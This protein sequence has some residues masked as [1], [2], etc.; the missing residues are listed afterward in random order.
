MSADGGDCDEHIEG[1]EC[2]ANLSAL[3][4][5]P[6]Q[7]LHGSSAALMGPGRSGEDVVAAAVL[8]GGAGV[9]M[10]APRRSR[11]SRAEAGLDEDARDGSVLDGILPGEEGSGGISF[12]VDF[13][14]DSG[15][16]GGSDDDEERGGVRRMPHNDSA[17]APAAQRPLPPPRVARA[18]DFSAG[19]TTATSLSSTSSAGDTS[20]CGG[21]GAV[22][23]DSSFGAVGALP[24]RPIL[25]APTFLGNPTF[26]VGAPSDASRASCGAS[27]VSAASVPPLWGSGAVLKQR[28]FSRSLFAPLEASGGTSSVMP[29][30]ALPPH[31]ARKHPRDYLR[32]EAAAS[33]AAATAAASV[34]GPSSQD[35]YARQLQMLALDAAPALALQS[36]GGSF[37]THVPLGTISGSDTLSLAS[38][39]RQMPA[40]TPAR[41]RIARARRRQVQQVRPLELSGGGSSLRSSSGYVLLSSAL[42]G[43]GGGSGSSSAAAGASSSQESAGSSSAWEQLPV[44]TGAR[45]AFHRS[46]SLPAFPH[47]REG[48]EGGASN[49]FGASS[50]LGA[51]TFSRRALPPASPSHI[52]EGAS[53]STPSAKRANVG[54]SP[55]GAVD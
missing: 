8:G 15:W 25:L 46:S 30:P 33:A 17:A 28:A 51:T 23:V 45:A 1:G 36:S 43:C 35:S 39:A 48:G 27:G 2:A 41:E 22:L 52:E 26:C 6:W 55:R 9:R 13:D 20:M 50:L 18:L 16:A 54:P 31:S 29:A 14:D 4:A 24:Q 32:A 47:C 37:S 12:S 44:A 7:P 10:H 49:V 34:A 19:D 42:E 21:S 5:V 38:L 11:L 40:C 3:S 53:C